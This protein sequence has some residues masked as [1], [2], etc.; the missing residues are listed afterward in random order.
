MPITIREL[1]ASDTISQAA[2][3]INFNF[4][5]LLLNGGGPQGPQ[6][7]QGPPGPIG[8]RGIRGSVWYEDTSTTSPG[9]NPN[10]VPPTLT[11]EDEDNYLQFNGVVWTYDASIPAWMPTNIDLTGPVGPPGASG[12]FAEYQTSPYNAAGDTTIF[13]DEI[14][15]SPIGLTQGVRSVLIGGFPE[16]PAFT[17]TSPPGTNIVPSSIA[18]QLQ[19]PDIS[20][21]VHQF[22]ASG[23]GIVFHGGDA[24]ENFEQVAATDLSSIGISND[25][26]M[27]ISVPKEPT[28]ASVQA[29]LDGLRV[30]T[31][32]RNQHFQAGKRIWLQAGTSST[33]YGAGDLA[34]VWI[35]ADRNTPSIPRPT[36]ELR[37]NDSSTPDYE[38]ELRLGGFGTAP[39]T[40]SKQG[41]FWVEAGLIDILSNGSTTVNSGQGITMNAANNIVAT[42]LS[43]DIRLNA[44]FG[45]LFSTSQTVDVNATTSIEIVAGTGIDIIAGTA[46]RLLSTTSNEVYSGGDVDIHS[47]DA[48]VNIS[49]DTGTGGDI[50]ITTNNSTVLEGLIYIGTQDD[51]SPMFLFTSG[52]NSGISTF[53]NG[54]A[55]PIS[56]QTFAASDIEL[57]SGNDINIV[58]DNNITIDAT[59]D[60]DID[61]DEITIDATDNITLTSSS[62][63]I[64][65]R[66]NST[67]GDILIQSGGNTSS[68]DLQRVTGTSVVNVFSTS[69]AGSYFTVWGGAD[70][71]T[72]GIR[73]WMNGTGA[74]QN[75]ANITALGGTDRINVGS[76]DG[77]GSAQPYDSGFKV[78]AK[79]HLTHFDRITSGVNDDIFRSGQFVKSYTTPA[80]P[81]NV[82]I[83]INWMRVGNVVTGTGLM[84]PSSPSITAGTY[85]V[86]IPIGEAAVNTIYGMWTDIDFPPAPITPYVGAIG[87]ATST[88]MR[89]AIAVVTPPGIH[90][91]FSYVIA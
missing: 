2:D 75:I 52:S 68:I 62:G 16:S 59:G 25:D 84:D 23:R 5:Q 22:N 13:P 14:S 29:D 56:L 27:V 83:K 81:S 28:L 21:M 79:N 88:K 39:T 24:T 69:G 61:A 20:M 80:V 65:L 87:Y 74:S 82:Q 53:T 89:I 45:E 78:D 91:T 3:K 33:Q 58:A 42:S 4:D 46:M 86:D 7:P 76:F 71:T 57:D 63:D 48:D 41:D 35:E 49:T 37:V 72:N 9:N 34:S 8:G 55:S 12:K 90:F 17:P 67:D 15:L 11:P 40:S 26:L 66:A 73:L 85:D 60:L 77:Q 64:E 31:P 6:G 36:I 18:S 44:P 32:E 54:T 47:R 30:L 10:T 51:S 50:S 19:M 1:L 38:A 70:D 43:A